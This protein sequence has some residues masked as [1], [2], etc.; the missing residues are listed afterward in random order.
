MLSL[1]FEFHSKFSIVAI[2]LLLVTLW[3]AMHGYHGITEDG[4]IY[5]FQAY[6]RLHP[7]LATDLYLQNTSQD[8]FTLFSPIYAWFIGL[9]GLEN[10]AR[11]LTLI[12]TFWFL[13]AAWSFVR[14]VAG[15]DA[16]WWATAFLL[17]IGG[18]YGGSGVFQILDPYLTARLPAGALVISA[19]SCV[20]RGMKRF[21][22]LLALAALLI[23]PLVALPGLLV[24]VCLWLPLRIS[25]AGAV[26]GVLMIFVLSVL[27]TT[28]PS[29]SHLLAVMDASWAGVVQERSQFL[30]P[31]LWSIRDWAVNVSPFPYL[32]FT[33]L[34][35]TDK[36]I[37]K[38]CVVAALVGGAGLS[39][40]LI[41]SV[42]GPVAILVQGQ[43]WRWLWIAVFVSAALAP[44]TLLRIWRD[45]KCGPLCGLL[46]VLGWTL[47]WAYGI[48]CAS[49]GLLVWMVRA[50]IS[51]RLVSHQW[52]PVAI[53]VAIVIWTLVKCWAIVSPSTPALRP[54]PFDVAQI[55][56]IFALKI[57]AVLL[58][59]LV[60]WAVTAKRTTRTLVAI[61]VVLAASS[62]LIFPAAFRQARTLA[63]AGDIQEFEDW[64]NVIPPTSMVLVAPPRDVGTFVWFTLA[65]P[66]YLSLDQSSGVVFS[67]TTSLEVWRRSE[68]LLPLMNPDWKILTRLS[69]SDDQLK[70]EAPTRPLT[71]SNLIAVCSD[72]LLGFV[73]SPE[74][75]GFDPLRHEHDGPWKDWALYDCQRVRSAPPGQMTT[76][77]LRDPV[78]RSPYGLIA[79]H[80][81]CQ[82]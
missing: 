70:K 12:C 14:A 62:L 38:L 54:S 6:A 10:A 7:Q 65:R 30:F 36:K 3:L 41:G 42:I 46:M 9:L 20:A 23:H 72:P 11:L 16:A 24:V 66:N 31:Q 32:A 57:P 25:V 58:G 22:L 68:V 47:P 19:L 73:I 45:E 2:A 26:G 21:G 80:D 76:V 28:R 48:I 52:F 82:R 59:A 75:V 77:A 35:V 51:A 53:S 74:N 27:A 61:S 1:N 63:A 39:V 43:A 33:G 49:L 5:A 60:F 78:C 67:R 4:Q 64:T 40:A 15:S 81:A 79:T 29:F 44:F 55:Q 69:K 8:Q 17:I 34:A 56:D 18:E 71:K 13:A 50:H 37:H